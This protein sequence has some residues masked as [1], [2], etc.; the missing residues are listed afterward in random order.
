MC[1]PTRTLAQ[2]YE[3]SM[4]TMRRDA[5]L[6]WPQR[7]GEKS[8]EPP[9]VPAAAAASEPPPAAAAA[10]AA[11]PLP[12]APGGLHSAPADSA[13]G[14]S[15]EKLQQPDTTDVGS[16]GAGRNAA[17]TS[18]ASDSSSSSSS[19][20]EGGTSSDT[21]GSDGSGLSDILG[22]EVDYPQLS[23]R[24]LLKEARGR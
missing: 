3:A 21:G 8:T 16:P 14:T 2:I 11:A 13:I 4:Q 18:P 5:H 23:P 10:D 15:S 7:D 9:A 1:A 22:L 6:W 19:D 24:E 17:D 20:S 12:T